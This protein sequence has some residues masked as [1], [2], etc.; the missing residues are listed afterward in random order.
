MIRSAPWWLVMVL[1]FVVGSAGAARGA[2]G[3]AVGDRAPNFMLVD[4]DGKTRAL[5]EFT[6][7]FIVLEWFNHACPFVGKHY[8]SGH[9]QQLQRTYTARGVAWVSINS[10]APGK[11]G[12]LTPAQAKAI[13]QEKRAVPTVVFLDPDGA[14]G[15]RYGAKATPHMFVINPEGVVIYA[16]AID[17]IASTDQSDLKRA[18]N[19]VEAALEETMAGRPV[20]V[21]STTAYG[22]SVK[23]RAMDTNSG[24]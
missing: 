14:V 6:G 4:A 18:T 11:E 17:S 1:V 16:G 10:S 3:V 7:K 13:T 24:S 19:Y 20:S 5:S 2:E 23:Y 8:G 9:M 22:C 15:R 21:P 12:C